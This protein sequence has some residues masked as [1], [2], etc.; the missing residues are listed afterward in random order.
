M[1]IPYKAGEDFVEYQYRIYNTR[2]KGIRTNLTALGKE[3]DIKHDYENLHNAL[4]DLELNL[5]I[6]NRLKYSLEL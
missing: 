3:F 6:W 1:D 5:K 4:V 2:R